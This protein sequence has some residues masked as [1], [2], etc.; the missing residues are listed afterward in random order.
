MLLR[1]WDMHVYYKKH[2]GTMSKKILSGTF[3]VSICS[4]SGSVNERVR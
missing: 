1:N 3:F 2:H 4:I